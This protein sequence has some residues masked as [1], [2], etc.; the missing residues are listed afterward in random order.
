MLQT[1]LHSHDDSKE[2]P[3]SGCYRCSVGEPSHTDCSLCMHPRYL[4]DLH[5]PV[6][7]FRDPLFNLRLR[8]RNS[9]Y[10]PTSNDDN[11]MLNPLIPKAR[12]RYYQPLSMLWADG[13]VRA[14]L[15]GGCNQ[16]SYS[17]GK[18]MQKVSE[19]GAINNI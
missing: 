6:Q 4:Y 14:I 17:D 8:I 19:S 12:V 2:H 5:L 11:N 9:A 16:I 18:G 13:S 15:F 7:S 10:R 3:A 1:D